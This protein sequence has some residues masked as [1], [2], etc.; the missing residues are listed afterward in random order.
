VTL[1][2]WPATVSAALRCDPLGFAAALNETVPLPFPL[3]P[4]VIDSHADVVDADQAQP[5]GAVTEN[6]LEPPAETIERLVG[7]TL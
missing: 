3:L 5:A 1:T 4:L 7:L 6:V 2:A